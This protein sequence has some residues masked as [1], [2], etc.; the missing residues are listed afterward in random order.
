MIVAE[1]PPLPGALC[2]GHDPFWDLDVDGETR[3]ERD[4]R[5]TAARY[6]CSRC[7]EMKP[8]RAW[9]EQAPRAR[10]GVWGGRLH[11]ERPR[12]TAET[13]PERA[14]TARTRPTAGERTPNTA[15]AA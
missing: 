3:Q 14:A 15:T 11:I 9:G 6:V 5:H 13:G 2:R 8:C 4:E 7:P 12:R 10:Y 1:A